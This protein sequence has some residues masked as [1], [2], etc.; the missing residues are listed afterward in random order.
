MGPQSLGVSWIGVF[1]GSVWWLVPVL[2]V[3]LL[4][5]FVIG[6]PASREPWTPQI[7][8]ALL[9]F[10]LGLIIW[11]L[12]WPEHPPTYLAWHCR[13]LNPDGSRCY[14]RASRR[15]EGLCYTHYLEREAGEPVVPRPEV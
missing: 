9:S 12:L 3:G 10:I 5:S 8:A 2:V 7:F 14:H 4:L 1:S 13:A 15:R 11:W 6:L